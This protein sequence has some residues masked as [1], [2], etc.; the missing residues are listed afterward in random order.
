[1]STESPEG[2]IFVSMES[3]TPEAP[4]LPSAWG[5]NWATLPLGI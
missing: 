3:G 5:Y 1:M 2:L 4:E